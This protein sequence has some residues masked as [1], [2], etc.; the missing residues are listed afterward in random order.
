VRRLLATANIV[1]SSPI[2]ATPTMETLR[3]SETSGLTT[4]T[5]RDIQEDGILHSHSR[6][7]LKCYKEFLAL[8]GNRNPAVEFII[9]IF[10]FVK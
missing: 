3:S 10:L 1:S 2:L 8:A 7:Y 6:E 9:I 4:S 5:L